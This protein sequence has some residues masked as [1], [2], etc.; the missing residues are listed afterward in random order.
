[1]SREQKDAIYAALRERVDNGVS[2]EV[3]GIHRD[4]NDL[5]DRVRFTVKI[6][7][8]DGLTF[9]MMQTIAEVFQTKSINV[10]PRDEG[11]CPTCGSDLKVELEIFN[12]KI[13][14][15]HTQ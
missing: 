5:R 15:E 14:E 6:D 11:N 7:E 4:V 3:E 13:P 8:M 12:A 10:N 2:W 9:A 1:M